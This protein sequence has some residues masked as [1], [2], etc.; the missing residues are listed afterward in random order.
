MRFLFFGLLTILF[1]SSVASSELPDSIEDYAK[2]IRRF[3][4]TNEN[5]QQDPSSANF[6]DVWYDGDQL[7]YFLSDPSLNHFSG[8]PKHLS[9]FYTISQW[10]SV[11]PDK[12]NWVIFDK[13]WSYKYQFY[14][15]S[16]QRKYITSA[17][18]ME[19]NCKAIV[20]NPYETTAD[21][22]VGVINKHLPLDFGANKML[23]VDR[24]KKVI[25][26]SWETNLSSVEQLKAMNPT[27]D[28][29]N[30]LKVMKLIKGYLDVDSI[31][32]VCFNPRY[33]FF[34]NNDDTIG[35]RFLTQSGEVL[36]HKILSKTDCQKA[37]TEKTK[38]NN[39]LR[40]F[41]AYIEE[42]KKR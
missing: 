8:D 9:A 37:E 19:S 18:V 14:D 39:L 35:I 16:D 21:Q 32:Q 27:G 22:I 29:E 41:L 7:V 15:T 4:I 6:F 5:L 33:Q 34:L 28:K 1:S 23:K 36:S 20:E 31:Q 11:C 30:D 2:Q 24:E 12:N 42:L 38:I 13:G 26:W 17:W 3:I 25:T 10:V 40:E